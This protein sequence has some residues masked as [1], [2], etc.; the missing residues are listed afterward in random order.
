[1]NIHYTEH[2]HVHACTY[3]NTN[4]NILN[5][6]LGSERQKT[7]DLSLERAGNLGGQRCLEPFTRDWGMVI[8]PDG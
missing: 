3:I 1:M 2:I 5:P 8:V 7:M 4:E 6:A